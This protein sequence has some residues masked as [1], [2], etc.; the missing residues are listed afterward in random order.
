MKGHMKNQNDLKF[1]NKGTKNLNINT[2]KKS[3]MFHRDFCFLIQMY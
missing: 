1:K 2:K 3:R